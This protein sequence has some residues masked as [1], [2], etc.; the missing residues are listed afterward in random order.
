MPTRRP[1]RPTRPAA[2]STACAFCGIVPVLGGPQHRARPG[3]PAASSPA[4]EFCCLGAAIAV[5]RE[6]IATRLG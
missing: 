5:Q 1:G 3:R 4:C 6:T 2:S